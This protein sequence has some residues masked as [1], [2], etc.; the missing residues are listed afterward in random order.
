MLADEKHTND[1][2]DSNQTVVFEASK[3]QKNGKK[4]STTSTH[5]LGISQAIKF[6][7]KILTFEF[8]STTT[9]SYSYA[10]AQ[11]EETY[12]EESVAIKYSVSAMIKPGEVVYC[13]ATVQTGTFTGDYSSTVNVLLDDGTSWSFAERGTMEEVRWAEAVSSCQETPFTGGPQKR[14]T[15]FIA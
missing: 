12:E 15:K 11:T 4:W 2:P 1:H 14:A 3:E 7:G 13:R 8:E 6:S 9:L 10:N 5:T